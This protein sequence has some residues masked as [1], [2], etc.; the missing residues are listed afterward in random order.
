MRRLVIDGKPSEPFE[1]AVGESE[2]AYRERL[3]R[4]A[5]N[6]AI[7]GRDVEVQE[8]PTWRPVLRARTSP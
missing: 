6:L 5:W 2:D 4:R 8:G 7:A 1:Q 3:E